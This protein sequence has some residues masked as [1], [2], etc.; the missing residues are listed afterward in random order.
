[1]VWIAFESDA[2]LLLENNEGALQRWLLCRVVVQC[3]RGQL[4]VVS[5]F[6][7]RSDFHL[8]FSWSNDENLDMIRFLGWLLRLSRWLIRLIDERT[9]GSENWFGHEATLC[10][11]IHLRHFSLLLFAYWLPILCRR[12]LMLLSSS[13]FFI[14]D[15]NAQW[16]SFCFLSATAVFVGW[17]WIFLLRSRGAIID[18]F[19]TSLELLL[20]V[21]VTFGDVLEWLALL[22]HVYRFL[23]ALSCCIIGQSLLTIDYHLQVLVSWSAF[24]LFQVDFSHALLL[25]RSV[26]AVVLSCPNCCIATLQIWRNRAVS[27]QSLHRFH[28]IADVWGGIWLGLLCQLLL[29]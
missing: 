2:D 21:F 17:P 23:F 24:F 15:F 8:L 18:L 7:P 14:L 12:I 28:L 5:W 19:L 22:F 29:K 6:G 10:R 20:H 11:F 13:I 25:C 27:E 1:M 26:F 16:F 3:R 4:V 9:F